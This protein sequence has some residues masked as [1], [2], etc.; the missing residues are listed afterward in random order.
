MAIKL[1]APPTVCAD[2]DAEVEV[3]AEHLYWL[4]QTVYVDPDLCD[5]DNNGDTCPATDE[6]HRPVTS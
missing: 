6:P 4:N 2:C 1:P 3:N 5:V